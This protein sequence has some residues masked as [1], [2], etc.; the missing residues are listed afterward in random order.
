[1]NCAKEITKNNGQWQWHLLVILLS[2]HSA[3]AG[4]DSNWR[5]MVKHVWTLMNALRASPVV[6]NASIRMEPTSAAVQKAMKYSPI[7]KMAAGH[8]QVGNWIC[9]WSKPSYKNGFKNGFW[10]VWPLL[11]EF[12]PY[13]CVWEVITFPLVLEY[14]YRDFAHHACSSLFKSRLHCCLVKN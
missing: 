3:S 5:M 10:I 9:S 1:M 13:S 11:F 4:L 2:F 8:S 12:I 6:S 7:T 14:W